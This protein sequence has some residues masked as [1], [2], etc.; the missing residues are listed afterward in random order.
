MKTTNME[1]K[2]DRGDK[3][4]RPNN[5]HMRAEHAK[6]VASGKVVANCDTCGRKRWFTPEEV[7]MRSMCEKCVFRG[8]PV[9]APAIEKHGELTSRQRHKKH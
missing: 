3:F 2:Q 9:E 5:A 4:T 7:A 8:P 6:L 1:W